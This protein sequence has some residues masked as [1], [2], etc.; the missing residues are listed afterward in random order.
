MLITVV[1][2]GII[3]P[4]ASA[5]SMPF[6]DVP[7]GSWFF[8]AVSWAYDN[9]IASGTSPTTFS[10]DRNITRAEFVTFLYRSEAPSFVSSIIHFNDVANP[11][12]FFFDSVNW[13]FENGLVVGTGGGRF[14]PNRN[15]TREE[16]AI[17]L[18]RFAYYQNRTITPTTIAL[19]R[20]NDGYKVSAFAQESV[21]WAVSTGILRG[22]HNL[23]LNPVGFATRAEAI[24]VIHRYIFNQPYTPPAPANVVEVRTGSRAITVR[25]SDGTIRAMGNNNHSLVN[26][27]GWNNIVEVAV[28]SGHM[29]GRRADGSLVAAGNPAHFGNISSLNNP[30][31]IA[32]SSGGYHVIVLRRD[33]TVRGTG[34]NQF[35]QLNVNGWSN[36]KAIAAGGNH[37]VGLRR[38]GSVVAAGRNEFNQITNANRLTGII[39]I[40]AGSMHTI[41]LRSNGT[42]VAVGSTWNPNQ[43][44]TGG[45]SNIRAVDAGTTHSV[46]LR[47]D[48][49]VVA[50]GENHYGQCNVGNWTNIIQISAAG[51]MTAGL[52]AD[53]RILVTGNLTDYGRPNVDIWN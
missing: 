19:N 50:T 21:L 9:N 53:G 13:A 5:A 42:V 8:D 47:Y 4:A 10:P 6:V 3:S 49:R 41:A 17:I 11:S 40:A 34:M 22:E 39:Q 35:G 25:L 28:G 20:F 16:M 31:N 36:I 37:V 48:G 29:A 32:I 15:I 38:D 14:E 24:I 23:R 2:L 1:L 7:P 27:G 12:Q 30:D 18:Y 51:H 33:G 26:V 46:G 43:L 45:W 44:S 52:R